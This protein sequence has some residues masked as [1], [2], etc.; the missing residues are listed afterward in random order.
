[1]I[2]IKNSLKLVLEGK[3]MAGGPG[4]Y[5]LGEEEKK[6]L[7]DVIENGSLFRSGGNAEAAVE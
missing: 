2:V 7:L 4:S 5:V 6:E 1:M 3:R